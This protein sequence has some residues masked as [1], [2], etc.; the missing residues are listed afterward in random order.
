[1]G[2]CAG[3]S[4]GF[5]QIVSVATGMTGSNEPSSFTSAGA[6]L[7]LDHCLNVR[8]DRPGNPDAGLIIDAAGRRVDH[9]KNGKVNSET[10]SQSIA[11]VLIVNR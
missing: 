10:G 6:E 2:I 7:A 3:L 8:I 1:M 4:G 5:F 11:S 9:G